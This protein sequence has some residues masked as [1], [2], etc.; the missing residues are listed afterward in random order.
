MRLGGGRAYQRL[1]PAFIGIIAGEL[2]AV[3][4]VVLV[5]FL[6]YWVTGYPTGVSTTIQSN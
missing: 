2:L 4:L 5:D 6:H 3:A 1:K